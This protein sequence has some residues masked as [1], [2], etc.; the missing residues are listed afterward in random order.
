MIHLVCVV[1]F[2]FGS[3]FVLII[4]SPLPFE[5]KHQQTTT[6]HSGGGGGVRMRTTDDITPGRPSIA[7]RE[8]PITTIIPGICWC[9]C[10]FV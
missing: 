4:G 1:V 6:T 7:P 9:C 10:Y 2:I 5:R 8:R 3:I